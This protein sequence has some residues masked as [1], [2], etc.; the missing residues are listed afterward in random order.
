MRLS[1]HPK[2][3]PA[4][5]KERWGRWK[6][7]LE[8]KRYERKQRQR[9]GL[10]ERI[11]VTREKLRL[12]DEVKQ[13][14]ERGTLDL[15]TRTEAGGFITLKEKTDAVFWVSGVWA[16]TIGGIA[17]FSLHAFQKTLTLFQ[18]GALFSAT[19]LVSTGM[20]ILH[21]GTKSDWF[22]KTVRNF[23]EEELGDLLKAHARVIGELQKKV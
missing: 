4:S 20:S 14:I 23:V 16:V 17:F 21:Y 9:A 19:L 12:F 10:E 8:Q 18:T 15:E 11:G 1:L 13:G 6:D 2:N 22:L 7:R 5:W 3:L